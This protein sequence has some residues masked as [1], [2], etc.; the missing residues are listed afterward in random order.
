MID[1]QIGKVKNRAVIVVKSLTT[2]QFTAQYL[3]ISSFN[4]T[5][6]LLKGWRDLR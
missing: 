2:A 1:N 3:L 4:S 5:A 6:L